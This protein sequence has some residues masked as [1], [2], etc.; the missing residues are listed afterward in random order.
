MTYEDAE[1]GFHEP[2]QIQAHLAA[3]DAAINGILER[4][5]GSAGSKR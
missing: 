5:E 3:Q 4:M 1:A 2:R